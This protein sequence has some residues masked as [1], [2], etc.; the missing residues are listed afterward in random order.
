MTE[1]SFIADVVVQA[2]VIIA[3]VVAAVAAGLA[4]TKPWWDAPPPPPPLTPASWVPYRVPHTAV[5]LWRPTNWQIRFAQDRRARVCILE[6][7][8][9][10]LVAL[11]V[12]PAEGG[13]WP[14]DRYAASVLD[15]VRPNPSFAAEAVRRARL[16]T[17]VT[18][19]LTASWRQLAGLRPITW[20]CE[21]RWGR[22]DSC[23]VVAWMI[24]DAANWPRLRAWGNQLLSS[25]TVLHSAD[26]P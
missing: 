18:S 20:Y 14:L 1:R 8:P 26:E 10:S 9:T 23:A 19:S 12:L 4:L 22:I 7:S 2:L 16:G 11:A 21:V 17:T 5:L 15:K 25:I 3:I 24:S 13:Q 6:A